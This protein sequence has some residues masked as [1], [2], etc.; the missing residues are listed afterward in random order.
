MKMTGWRQKMVAGLA[1]GF[2]ALSGVSQAA[3]ITYNFNDGTLQGWTTVSSD[4]A[5]S[6]NPTR[7]E[8]N[9]TYTAQGGS[10]YSVWV[11]NN[12]NRDQAH[13]TLWIRSETF[14][15]DQDGELSFWLLSGTG[16]GGY[17]G[18]QATLPTNASQI[19][20]GVDSTL[21]GVMG[22]ALRDVATGNFVRTG[23]RS[24]SD[25]SIWEK[26]SMDVSGLKDDGKVYTLELFDYLS[27]KAYSSIG[28][29][30]VSIP[31]S[32]VTIPEPATVGLLGL[33][34]VAL[35]LRRRRRA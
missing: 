9:N 32:V 5:N 29:D 31:G 26:I 20:L 34:A 24:Y 10:G 7:F 19:P 22:V 28:L 35:V 6:P 11:D 3:M 23:Q 21:S 12:N 14:K 8:V 1:L 30:T 4:P 33:S 16:A 17:P 15:I 27:N 13:Q 18:T 25:W 2:W